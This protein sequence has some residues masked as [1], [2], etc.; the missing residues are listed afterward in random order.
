METNTNAKIRS[1][2][3]MDKCAAMEERWNMMGV[4]IGA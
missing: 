4:M 3:I 2:R 1:K